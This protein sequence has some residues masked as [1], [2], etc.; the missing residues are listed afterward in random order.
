M[1]ILIIDDSIDKITD[2]SSLIYKAFPKAFIETAE[3][4]VNASGLLIKNN[5]NLAV[6]DLFL[7]LRKGDNPKQSGGKFLLEEIYRKKEFKIPNYIIGFTQHEESSTSFSS[8]W[9]TIKYNPG[10]DEWKDSFSKVLYHIQNTSFK[11]L[12]S[13][14]EEDLIPRFYVEGL[15]DKYYLEQSISLFFAKE[16]ETYE[17]VSQKNAGANWVANQIPIWAMKH[18]KDNNGNYIKALGLLDSDIAGNLAK[19]KIDNR[20]LSDNEQKCFSIIQLKPSYNIDVLEFYKK[21]VKIEIEIETLFP[22]EVLKHAENNQWLEH[23]N[24]L[25]MSPPKQWNQ[26]E[27][28]LAQYLLKIGIYEEK[29]IYLKKVKTNSKENFLKYIKSLKNKKEVYSNFK[30]L[31][32]DIFI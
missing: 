4:I 22:Y 5:Y 21:G 19:D 12:D 26:F 9:S 24:P 32:S 25:C 15:T 11:E 16:I 31:L 14:I 8:I 17:I 10:L 28:T 2:L 23:R 3:N 18:Q 30:F 27:E 6:I 1:R 13:K 7:P 20:N 29:H